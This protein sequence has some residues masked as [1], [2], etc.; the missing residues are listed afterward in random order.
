MKTN[1][2]KPTD[3]SRRDFL[4]GGSLAT[5]MTLL[6]GVELAFKPQSACA[7]D[8]STLHGPPVKL[9]VIG[10][11]AW[12]REIL[13]TLTRIPEANVVAICDRYPAFLRRAAKFAEKAEAVE[14][15]RRILENKEIQ[16]VI[17]A[18]PSHQHREVAVAALQAG[19]HVYCEA[20]LATSL[21]DARAIALTARNA[22]K[23]VFQAGLQSRSDPQRAFVRSFIRSGAVGKPVMARG[24]W[25]KKQSWRQ[26]SPNV[27]REKELNW[28]LNPETSLG[29]VGEIGIHHLDTVSWFFDRLPAAV[30]AR[31]SICHWSD[32]R[33]APDTVQVV[34]ELP[35]G[36]MAS[37]DGTLANSFLSSQEVICGS[38]AAVL[39]RDARAWWFKEVDAPLLGWEVYAMKEV[40]CEETGIV[41]RANAT[42]STNQD[43]KPG[44]DKAS[45]TKTALEWA[46]G[47][48]LANVNEVSATVED[49][50]ASFNPNDKA[51]LLKL[52]SEVKRQ[53]AAG[54]KEGYEATVAVIKANEAM[55]RGQ[56]VVL[57]KDVFELV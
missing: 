47:N 14:D 24:Q 55:V 48:F 13:T 12:G 46:L 51:A 53:P 4:K 54:Y 3:V 45:D 6:G 43:G 20:P 49:F 7:V 26:T 19:K 33:S 18:T 44:E 28:R 37:W 52:L 56:R 30:T 35:D 34:F 22:P 5:A 41:L 15:C 8:A 32:G 36:A 31:G 38:D 25:F 1:H 23:Q 40:V 29:L 2:D 17:I 39:L 9:A 21:E 42:K 11:G 10:L 50:N 57:S 27:E 16:A